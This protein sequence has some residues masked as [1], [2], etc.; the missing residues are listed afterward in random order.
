MR[1]IS[2][3]KA[4]SKFTYLVLDKVSYFTI[5]HDELTIEVGI[6]SSDN[7]VMV[8]FED[9]DQFHVAIAALEDAFDTELVGN[10]SNV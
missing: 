5:M 1:A 9:E 2:F 8:E 10:F 7:P 3:R 4:K 6:M